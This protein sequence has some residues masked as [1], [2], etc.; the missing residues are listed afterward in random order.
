LTDLG[1]AL[2][3]KVIVGTDCIVKTS[4]KTST[5]TPAATSINSGERAPSTGNMTGEKEWSIHG[6]GREER[7]RKTGKIWEGAHQRVL[8]LAAKA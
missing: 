4:T 8:K 3:P 5:N 1:E 7:A 2:F 6:N